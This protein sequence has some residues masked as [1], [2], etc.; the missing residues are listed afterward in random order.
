MKF[1]P[2]LYSP[3]NYPPTQSLTN[4]TLAKIIESRMY[5]DTT[6]RQSIP[7]TVSRELDIFV[8][9]LAARKIQ[10]F[11]TDVVAGDRLIRTDRPWQQV[12]PR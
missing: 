6:V 3:G 7:S 8:N 12:F 10:Q 5:T 2:N 1:D 9:D 11:Y 4:A